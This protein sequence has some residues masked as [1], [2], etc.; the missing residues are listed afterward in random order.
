MLETCPVGV[1]VISAVGR[2]LY[3]NPRAANLFGINRMTLA[4]ANVRMLY[5]HPE[6]HD[7]LMSTFQRSGAVHQVQMELRRI[8][9]P[10]FWAR[11]SWESAEF[12][13]QDAIV[14]WI[15]DITA[16][17]VT[18]E[19]LERLF[20]AAPAP[21]MLCC[22]A[23]GEIRRA[24]RRAV[25]LFIPG[26]KVTGCRLDDITGTETCR[27]F[28]LRLR[29]GGY[30]DDFELMLQT[31]YGEAFCGTLSGQMVEV[32]DERCVLVSVT[33]I[34]DRK[35]AEDT[36]RRFFDGA[37]LAMLLVRTL[38]RQVLR[39]N[40]RASELFATNRMRAS[41]AMDF[42]GFVGGFAANRFFEQLS[43]GGFVDNFEAQLAT[44]YGES[45]WAIISGQIVEIDDERCVLIGVT[46]ITDRRRGEEELRQ[47]KEEAERATQ[48]KSLF[49][50]TMSHEIRT[51]MNGVLGM[52]DVLATTDLSDEQEEM[53]DVVQSSARTLLT[54][55]DDILDLSKIE[56][57]KLRLE[58]VALKL[59]GTIESTIDLVATRAREKGLEVAWQVEAGMADVYL[60][61]PVRLRQI[62]LNL[63]GNAVKFT[64]AGS[65]T[66]KVCPVDQV[67][68]L[69]ALRFEI[70]D[71][72]I[73]LTEEQQTRL[74]QPFSQADTSTTRHFGGTGLGLSICRRL[75]GMMGGHIGV[76]S[77]EGR[78]ST[79]W[80]E[81]PLELDRNEAVPP[82]L[83]LAASRVLVMDDLAVSRACIAACLSEHGALV[84]E[85]TSAE[86]VAALLADGARFDAA[87]LDDGAGAHETATLLGRVLPRNAIVPMALSQ[88]EAQ[89]GWAASADL[90]PALVKPV[91]I[92]C[93]I[94]SVGVVLGRVCE[95]PTPRHTSLAARGGAPSR[96]KRWPTAP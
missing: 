40:R 91:R 11:V 41:A 86:E 67:D 80:F 12:S 48:A 46:D 22:L 92:S 65:V 32:A 72:G 60:G 44:D 2:M 77:E 87:V 39:I 15:E 20:D 13:G 30:V 52:L 94:R 5:A 95:L 96:T 71:T 74:F 16:H 25:E 73:G 7:A 81:I 43:G 90:A 17:K 58:R 84:T 28:L 24:N 14:L 49:L 64:Q 42:A 27:T 57:G 55:I 1:I 10:N 26:R 8:G 33:D 83:D 76:T 18:E 31:A 34:T 9:R 23:T 89:S 70:T 50:A 19:T 38:D 4:E 45:F 85:A 6:Q 36:L 47:A 75:V 66:L 78:G 35:R 79:F 56:A 59:R 68:H 53:V 3:A 21:M 54:I 69:V 88:T 93:L 82:P 62:M 29:G 61:D 37:P 63:L 51:P